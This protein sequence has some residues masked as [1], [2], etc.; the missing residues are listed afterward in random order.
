MK[1]NLVKEKSY[2]FSQHHWTI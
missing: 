1:D 2:S